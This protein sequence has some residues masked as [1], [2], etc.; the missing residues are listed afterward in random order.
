MHSGKS[1]ELWYI[2]GKMYLLLWKKDRKFW[3]IFDT[4]QKAENWP[5]LVRSQ[6]F[7]YKLCD[8][9]PFLGANYWSNLG[10]FIDGSLVIFDI[11]RQMSKI[12]VYFWHFW[13]FLVYFG[14]SVRFLVSFVKILDIRKLRNFLVQFWPSKYREGWNTGKVERLKISSKRPALPLTRYLFCFIMF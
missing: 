6:K 8:F 12:P 11:S 2:F 13:H 4:Y 5:F 1:F 14:F 9:R 3:Y 10:H 7:W